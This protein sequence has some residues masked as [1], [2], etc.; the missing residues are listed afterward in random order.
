MNDGQWDTVELWEDGRGTFVT[1]SRFLVFK[2][3]SSLD[4][5]KIIKACCVIIMCTCLRI[6]TSFH[7]SPSTIWSHGQ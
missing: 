1:G 5:Q 7:A 2:M 3:F 4:N 6:E